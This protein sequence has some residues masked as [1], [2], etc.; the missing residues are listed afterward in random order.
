M[1]VLSR[2]DVRAALPMADAMKAAEEA[3]KAWSSGRARIPLRTALAC[4]DG[5]GLSL[6]MPGYISGGAAAGSGGVQ[7]ILGAKVVSIFESNPRKG[8][9]TTQAV[10]LLI[11]P[12]T[13]ETLAVIEA[14]SLTAI[15]TGA[16]TGVAT[17][18]LARRDSSV[19]TVFGA[20]GQARTQLE[21]IACVCPLKEVFVYDID[22]RRAA[23][24]V[25]EMQ[26]Y[27]QGMRPGV[28]LRVAD[29]PDWAVKSSDIVAC[30][31]TSSTPLFRGRS[32]KPGTHVNAIGSYTPDRRELDEELLLSAGK[33]VV[34]SREAV[35]SEAGDLIIP[36]VKGLFSA[37]IIKAEV[38][39]ILLGQRPGRESPEEIT[40]YK[41]VGI[42]ALDLVSA[43]AAYRRATELG[44]GT[45]V[46][47]F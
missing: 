21:A 5:P 38:G 22:G 8:L 32:V 2:D 14:G 31:T 25:E 35:L 34:D 40:V 20:G 10:F 9:A 26:E 27:L 44:L 45:Q 39:E 33:V 43:Q 15:R 36:I 42:G 12:E 30:A 18:M 37:D 19:A 24:F 16:A 29:D 41:A 28:H 4:P 7:S 3:Y 1:L 6:F 23:T 11:S 13:G 17:R 46:A 47:G